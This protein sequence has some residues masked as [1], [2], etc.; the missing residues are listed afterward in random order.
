MNM[1]VIYDET[2]LIIHRDAND[3]DLPALHHRKLSVMHLGC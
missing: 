1:Q 3:C 2:E